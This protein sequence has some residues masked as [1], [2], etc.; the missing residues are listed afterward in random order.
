MNDCTCANYLQISQR[1]LELNMVEV[2]KA[3]RK[4]VE[5]LYVD[6]ILKLKYYVT[7]AQQTLVHNLLSY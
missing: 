5:L 7:H 6:L 3:F 2:M 4:N 1:I